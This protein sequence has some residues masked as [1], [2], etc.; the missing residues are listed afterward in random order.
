MGRRSDG[1][2][3]WAVQVYTY[4]ARSARQAPPRLTPGLLLPPPRP[5]DALY[6]RINR[7]TH[8]KIVRRDLIRPK[9]LRFAPSVWPR[10]TFVD[11]RIGLGSAWHQSRRQRP[12]QHMRD[13]LAY[14]KNGK[15]RAFDASGFEVVYSLASLSLAVP[16]I[17]EPIQVV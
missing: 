4:C 5:S 12:T 17:S 13:L 16:S 10:C 6:F 2:G 14:K 8:W 15:L 7:L 11:F 9:R 1:A 3:G